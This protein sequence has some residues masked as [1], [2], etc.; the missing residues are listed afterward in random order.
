MRLQCFERARVGDAGGL[1]TRQ[2]L[3]VLHRLL[4]ARA[5]VLVVLD[6]VAIA[7][8]NAEGLQ[9]LLHHLHGGTTVA[10]F[11]LMCAGQREV[12]GFRR[13]RS[14]QHRLD[15]LALFVLGRAGVL[16]VALLMLMF[17]WPRLHGL[18]M[19][20]CVLLHKA[21]LL[22]A[23]CLRLLF[24]LL[25]LRGPRLLLHVHAGRFSVPRSCVFCRA[26]NWACVCSASS[27]PGSAMP[28]GSRPANRWKFSTACWVRGP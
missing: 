9:V 11:Q 25:Q 27:V 2:P 19:Q 16:A 28:V 23:C 1:A 24:L 26:A 13:R 10:G 5:V 21:V 8:G 12:W 6:R 4:G 15:R 20:L 17:A 7:V 14:V 18:T 22:L 3:E